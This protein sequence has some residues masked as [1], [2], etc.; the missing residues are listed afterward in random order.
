M[1]SDHANPGLAIDGIPNEWEGKLYIFKDKGLLVGVQD[2]SRDVYV[3]V[4]GLDPS[5]SRGMMRGGVTIWFDPG[6]GEQNRFGVHY[7]GMHGGAFREQDDQM[8]HPMSP[9]DIEILGPDKAIKMKIPSISSEQEYGLKVALR[10]S[11]GAAVFEMKVPRGVKAGDVG[12]E[13][14]VDK[15]LGVEVETSKGPTGGSSSSSR[16]DGERE[17]EG[18]RRGG[19]MRGGMGRGRPEGG[20]GAEGGPRDREGGRKPDSMSLSLRVHLAS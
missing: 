19:G 9:A 6:S 10:D 2:D 18:G 14:I 13:Q 15:T 11:G 20:E 12:L 7:G 3:C 4:E 17:G 8:F 5:T 1:T 16:G